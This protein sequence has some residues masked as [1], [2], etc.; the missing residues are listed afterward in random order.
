MPCNL[1]R[2]CH[3]AASALSGLGPAGQHSHLPFHQPPGG[4][5]D[6]LAQD[7]GVRG[8]LH[9]G[10]RSFIHSPGIGHPRDWTVLENPEARPKTDQW[11][12]PSARLAT[13]P[14]PSMKLSV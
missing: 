3:E 1:A 7:I 6:H 14:S 12:P 9:Q 11:P 10:A 13:A 5:A 4:E 2:C 8:I